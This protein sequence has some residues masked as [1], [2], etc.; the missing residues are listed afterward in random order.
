VVIQ[1]RYHGEALDERIIAKNILR[2]LQVRFDSII[3]AIE[4][5]KDL[6]HFSMDY[7]DA[8]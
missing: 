4:E 5:T 2:S 8:H 3:A 7:I 6:S 1:I